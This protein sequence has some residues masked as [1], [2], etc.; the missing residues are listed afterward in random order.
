MIIMFI[1]IIMLFNMR[2]MFKKQNI[3]KIKNTPLKDIIALKE[4]L[5]R[6]RFP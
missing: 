3:E 1:M 5:M 2:I 4:E 6:T